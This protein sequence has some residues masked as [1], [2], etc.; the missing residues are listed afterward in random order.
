MQKYIDYDTLSKVLDSTLSE[1]LMIPI[2]VS[3]NSMMPLF[4]DQVTIVQLVAPK[5]IQ[6]GDVVLFQN[7]QNRFVLHRVIKFNQVINQVITRGD[8][9]DVEDNPVA[10]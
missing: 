1:D 5:T 6:K 10:F 3:G 7:E 9:N 2:V 4:Q 8:A